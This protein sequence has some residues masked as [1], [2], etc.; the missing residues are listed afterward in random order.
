MNTI[1]VVFHISCS[2]RRK[3]LNGHDFVVR[4]TIRSLFSRS[5]AKKVYSHDQVVQRS[6]HEFKIMLQYSN[7]GGSGIRFENIY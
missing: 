5:H 4:L 6:G 7:M 1:Y 3:P 2:Q